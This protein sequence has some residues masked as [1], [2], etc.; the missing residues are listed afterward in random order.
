MKLINDEMREI[1]LMAKDTKN[2]IRE[3]NEAF[4]GDQEVEYVVTKHKNKTKVSKRKKT[5]DARQALTAPLQPIYEVDDSKA[6]VQ[7]QNPKTKKK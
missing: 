3:M 2:A 6:L 5:V 1:L 7:F 4:R